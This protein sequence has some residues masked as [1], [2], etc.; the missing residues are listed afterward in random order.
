MLG[1]WALQLAFI[2]SITMHWTWS[3]LVHKEIWHLNQSKHSINLILSCD[4]FSL[5]MIMSLKTSRMNE[6]KVLFLFVYFWYWR[7]AIKVSVSKQFSKFINKCESVVF[8]FSIYISIL[9]CYLKCLKKNLDIL[10]NEKFILTFFNTNF[11][12]KGSII[13]GKLGELEDNQCW[14]LGKIYDDARNIYI[15]NLVHERY[16]HT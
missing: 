6:K 14:F 9:C 3:I 4:A 15:E 10:R 2:A 8:C 1:I 13:L 7:Y 16:L 12:L 5:L 11:G